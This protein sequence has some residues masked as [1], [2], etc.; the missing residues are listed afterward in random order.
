M[1]PE[2]TREEVSIALDTLAMEVL[3]MAGVQRPP[4]DTLAVARALG[5]RVALD[6]RQQGRARCVRLGGYRG[7]PSRPTI[8]LQ[9]DPR[10]ERRHW[11][12]AHEIGEH[13]AHR[14]FAAL[15]VDPREVTP[16]HREATANHLAG[17]L[18]LPA[19][20]FA[21][22]AT[23]CGWDLIELK[24]RYA[25]ASHELIARRMLDLPPPVIITIYDQN[26]L[27]LR[28]GNLPGR[29]PLPSDVERHCRQSVHD[30]NRPEHRDDGPRAVQGWPV[31]ED[32]WRREILRTEVE[33]FY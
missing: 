21:E 4:V 11:A 5:I 12:I 6:D 18:L 15:G 7:K 31:H 22:D 14:A 26:R 30:R 10:N 20:W 2:L 1:L 25:T 28:R 9:P 8:L 23:A 17:R 13:V 24:R 32:G 33:E 19:V 27:T 29:V 16:D 3:T